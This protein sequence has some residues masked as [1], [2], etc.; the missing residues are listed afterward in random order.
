VFLP[1]FIPLDFSSLYILLIDICF[2]DEAIILFKKNF[3][4]TVF[5]M[6]YLSAKSLYK[7]TLKYSCNVWFLYWSS[8]NNVSGKAPSFKNSS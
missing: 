7:S 3:S 4:A 1:I 5:V 6:L 2:V 8:K